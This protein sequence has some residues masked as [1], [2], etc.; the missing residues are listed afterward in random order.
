LLAISRHI[1]AYILPSRF[2]CGKTSKGMVAM[3]FLRLTTAATVGLALGCFAGPSFAKHTKLIKV[4]AVERAKSEIPAGAAERGGNIRPITPEL[5]AASGKAAPDRSYAGADAAGAHSAAQRV[6]AVFALLSPVSPSGQTV[7]LPEPRPAGSHPTL[8]AYAEPQQVPEPPSSAPQGGL[9]AI[10]ALVD[11]H[12]RANHVPPALAHALVRI[13]SNYNPRAT[14]RHG[15]V[16][17]LQINPRT[18]RA[19]GYRGPRQA[20][21]DPKTNL[22]V[23]MKYLGQA[24]KLA[25]GDVCGTLLRYNAGLDARRGTA[26]TSRFCAKVKSKMAKAA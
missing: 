13:E 9:V 24:Q 22:T 5:I 19:M 15:E 4:A 3:H 2:H 18:A 14:G 12:A 16:G 17:L 7:R 8:L 25:G 26:G 6:D 1:L 23:G 10:K 11:Q 20:L 21:Y